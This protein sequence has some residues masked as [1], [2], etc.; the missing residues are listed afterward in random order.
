MSI[1]SHTPTFKG[2]DAASLRLLQF[3]RFERRRH[4]QEPG[5]ARRRLLQEPWHA[6]RRLLQ[7]PWHARRRLL[8]EPWQARRRLLHVST[9]L[10]P[11]RRPRMSM[12]MLP[13]CP[14]FRWNIHPGRICSSRCPAASFPRRLFH[15]RLVF[16]LP[17][18]S[19]RLPWSPSQRPRLSPIPDRTALYGPR[20]LACLSQRLRLSLPRG[21]P[22]PCLQIRR[23]KSCLSG[24]RV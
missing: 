24:R 12:P 4:L 3:P 8:Q 1:C 19:P 18:V 2:R 22:W 13:H 14:A 6:M 9:S 15:A 10:H 21:S 11:L 7:E 23:L 20:H 5:Y 17:P 16:L